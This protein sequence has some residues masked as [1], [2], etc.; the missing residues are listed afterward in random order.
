MLKDLVSIFWLDQK[1]IAS[2][3]FDKTTTLLPFKTTTLLL[4]FRL[5][6]NNSMSRMAGFRTEIK[7]I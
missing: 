5:N 7:E 6:T 2:L 4:S 3:K 1:D